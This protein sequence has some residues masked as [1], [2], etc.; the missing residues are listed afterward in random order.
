MADPNEVSS[1]SVSLNNSGLHEH[2]DRHTNTPRKHGNA[3]M[4]KDNRSATGFKRLQTPINLFEDECIFCHSFRTSQFHGPMVHYRKGKLVS[5]DNDSPSDIIYV[6]KKCMEWAPRVYYKGDTVVNMEMEISRASK[7]KCTRCRHPGAALG[8]YYKH[9]NRSY[10]VP[11]A[12]MTL[13]CRWDVDNCFVMC[14]EHASEALPCDKV[15]SPTKENGNSSS[16]SQ[17]QSS[18]EQRNSTGCERKDC[19]IDQRNISSS[20]PQR[21]SSAKEGISAVHKREIDQ[22]DTSCASFP[23]G[24][25]LDK[26]VI[27]TEDWRKQKQNHLYTERNCPSDLWVLLGSALSPSEKDSLKEFASW[28]NATVANEW[29]ENVT[30][31]IVGKSGDSACSRSYEV[32]MALLFGKWVLTIGWIM[33]SMEELIPSPESSFELRFSHDSRTSIGGNKKGRNQASEGAQKLFSGLNFCLSAYI[34]PDDRKHIQNLIAAAG[35]QVLKISGSHSVRENLEKAPA[36]PLY[37]VFDGGAPREFTPSL[38]DDL[39]KEMEEGIEHAACGAQVIS[40]LK[41]FDTI[42]ASDAHILNHKDHFTPYV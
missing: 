40:H 42:A 26:E 38:L 5:S 3:G 39:P 7:L 33:N 17:S 35:G 19:I 30:H 13:D 15:S 8:C 18:I 24:Q 20:L 22:P 4:S 25:Y 14:P 11:C 27:Y 9:C 29:T 23:Q 1:P 21:Q 32:L 37:F 31:V 34:N 36:E 16:I 6:H 10:H 2:S 12:V 28:T 41:L